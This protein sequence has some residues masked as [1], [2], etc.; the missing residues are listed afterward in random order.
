MGLFG[1]QENESTNLYTPI[2]PHQPNSEKPAPDG[3]TVTAE[4]LR[5]SEAEDTGNWVLDRCFVCLFNWSL[6]IFED[7]K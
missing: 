3:G 1:A 6:V 7:V 4:H 5:K 2:S